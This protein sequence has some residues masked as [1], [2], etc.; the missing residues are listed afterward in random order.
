M[1]L[2]LLVFTLLP[3]SSL[4][5][6]SL[7]G[8]YGSS[9]TGVVKYRVSA[10]HSALGMVA[11]IAPSATFTVMNTND[12]GAGSLRQAILDANA[13]AGLDTI[14]FN[15]SGSGVR[16]IS[17]ASALPTITD[18]TIID[19]YTQPG[20]SPNTQQQGNNAVLLIEIDGFGAGNTTSGLTITGGGSTIKG[21]VINR[22]RS[23]GLVFSTNGGNVVQ[24]NFIGTD[25]TGT[26]RRANLGIG[27]N[28]T[29][30]SN[31]LIG[32]T[33]PGD[34]NLVSGN[35]NRGISVSGGSNNLIQGNYVGT[36]AAGTAS[37]GNGEG[38]Y[39]AVYLTGTS[40][41]LGGTAAGA[42]NLIS[43]NFRE[44]VILGTAD[45]SVQGNFI[46]TNAS[47][48]AALANN[49]GGL[50]I[51]YGPNTIGGTVPTA[52][53]VISG[54]G[55]EGI[56]ITG[57]SATGNLVQGN[58]IG[59][60]VSGTVRIANNGSGIRID[61]A[62]GN[63]IG[64]TATGARNV[65]AGNVSN[66]V[67]IVAAS[68]NNVQGNF[69]G[70]DVSGAQA[71]SNSQGVRIIASGGTAANNVIGGTTTEDR[72]IISGNGIGVTIEGNFGGS[73]V[74][75]T[76]VEGNYLG[77]DVGGTINLGNLAAFEID[78][79]SGVTIGGGTPAHGNIIANSTGD[80][81]RINY[82]TGIAILSNRIYNNGGLG[83]NLGFDS[84]TPNDNC[85]VDTG[86][87]NLQNYPVL[88]S[89]SSS[90][91]STR[92]IG[93]LNS[94]PNI[95][96][97]LQ[98]FANT[99]CDPSGHGEGAT[100][101]GT[102][103]VSTDGS[104]NGSFDVSLPVSVAPGSYITGLATDPN[105]NSSEFSACVQIGGGGNTPTP[106]LTS[107]ATATSLPPSA[108]RT[109]TSTSTSTPVGATSTPGAATPTACTQ[110]F[111]D[112]QPQDTFYPF[113]RC[114]ACRGIIGGYADGTF[115]P[116]N[117]ITRGQIAK[118]VSNAA[119]FSETLPGQSFE[120][121]PPESPFY[122]FIERL[123]R[124]GIMGG[125]PC[126]QRQIETCVPPENRP[127]F[128][129]NEDATRGQ[130]SKIVSNAAGYGEPH[131]GQFYSDVTGDNPFYLE[132]MRLTTRGVMSGYPCG[133]EGEPCDTE[134]RPYFRWGNPVT[135]GQASKIVANTF[136]PG[137]QTPRR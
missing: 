102:G 67:S 74:A 95:T 96:Y 136:Y 34:R 47:G 113:I 51:G 53:N 11:P 35:Y 125:Y 132:I 54:N 5:G 121:V 3:S 128:R 123:Y 86:P 79:A 118:M 43:G 94:T 60:D 21:L 84:V 99:A 15:I 117:N 101:L 76:R 131:T 8:N 107:T 7:L 20:A 49:F 90:G 124:R 39:P 50:V 64:G 52:R 2:A 115:R 32:G 63:Q 82:S 14:A 58:Y 133:G 105:G 66:G 92:V 114:L 108:T 137:C 13:N 4:A 24:G 85:D 42:G 104:C 83:V 75:G 28:M 38:E 80:G 29:S 110:S 6:P 126:G 16:T 77:T 97:T 91:G 22:F 41:M 48:T 56:R 19:G 122:L 30:I 120:D 71:L 27:V 135:R 98:F 40:S 87:N 62:P 70:V 88:T 61:N 45:S 26:A 103:T 81:L 73:G 36:N 109:S 57:S 1:I 106:I 69:I 72:N 31:N 12:T 46:G 93:T 18:P 112:V 116:N 59:T 10:I 111:T 78:N 119:G 25:S 65:I 37:I 23:D 89:A 100:F 127:Y 33:N 129:P 68:S 55:N 130:L 44:G 17:P 9:S 134:N